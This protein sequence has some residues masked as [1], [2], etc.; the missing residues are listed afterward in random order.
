MWFALEDDA[1][2]EDEDDD[3]DDGADFESFFLACLSSLCLFSSCCFLCMADDS[4]GG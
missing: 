1:E 3:S 2:D 4:L